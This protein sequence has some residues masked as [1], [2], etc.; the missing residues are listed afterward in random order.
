[1]LNHGI[2][3]R[4]D[5]LVEVLH[6]FLLLGLSRCYNLN[7]L[8][9][10]GGRRAR[11]G[12]AERFKIANCHEFVNWILCNRVSQFK[13]EDFKLQSFTEFTEGIWPS[14]VV[15]FII[16]NLQ[17]AGVSRLVLQSQLP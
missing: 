7:Y 15:I 4:V 2:P 9:F 17:N 5:L 8:K 14:T 10:S 16:Y 6:L 3:E 11:R 1:M 13:D 12:G